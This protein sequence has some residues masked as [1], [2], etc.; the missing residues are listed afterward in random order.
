MTVMSR[1]TTAT[2]MIIEKQKCDPSHRLVRPV[3][4]FSAFGATRDTASATRDTG[5]RSVSGW[6]TR[7]KARFG[8]PYKIYLQDSH[9]RLTYKIHS[10]Q[11][12]F[13]IYAC[14]EER[15]RCQ[16]EEEEGSSM[17]HPTVLHALVT[18]HLGQPHTQPST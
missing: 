11:E 5:T 12:L 14:G 18:M 3:T 15:Y 2:M 10:S 6:K 1:P 4:Q 8:C 7:I 13:N 17:Y 16:E 9:T